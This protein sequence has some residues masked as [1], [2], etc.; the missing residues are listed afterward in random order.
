[1]TVECPVIVICR[2]CTNIELCRRNSFDHIL[3]LDAIPPILLT[4][5]VSVFDIIIVAV[6]L[7]ISH[8]ER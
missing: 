8:T 3:Q 6:V 1:M 2:I 7:R 4:I 5:V